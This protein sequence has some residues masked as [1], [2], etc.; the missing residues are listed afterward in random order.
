MTT[1]LMAMNGP[2][3]QAIERVLIGGDLSKLSEAQRVGYYNSV[4][5]SLGLNPLTKPFDYINLQ[6][7]LTLYARRDA[8]EQLR[9]IHGVSIVSLEKTR[10]DDLYVVTATACDK[11]GRT[12]ASTGA[13]TL[14]GLTGEN[15]ANAI[16]KAETKAKRR[17]TLSI[18]GL[19]MLDETEA[20]DVGKAAAAA[21]VVEAPSAERVDETTGEVVDAK[22]T[23]PQ[24]APYRY[25]HAIEPGHGKKAGTIVL[26]DGKRITV[27]ASEQRLLDIALQRCQ[28]GKPV[29][30]TVKPSND[31]RW[32]DA[33]KTLV[34]WTEE[35]TEL[36][37]A[38]VPAAPP[39][40]V[41]S[42]DIP[43]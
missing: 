15:L 39:V 14:K 13:V 4:C 17:V 20:A 8:T 5:Q 12:D 28:D 3:A 16:M 34:T 19:G 1:A 11:T 6:G 41:D 27:W 33:L 18:C 23:A 10:M 42:A 43:F 40:D 35:P 36:E 25:I 24:G 26:C 32:D 30:V 31:S 37:S 9:K 29:I 22:P 38:P 21:V 7:K 2:D